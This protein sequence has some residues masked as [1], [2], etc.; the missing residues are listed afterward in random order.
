MR[1]EKETEKKMLKKTVLFV[2]ALLF[3]VNAAFAAVNINKADQAALEALP[4]IGA[5]K[6]T[7]II[8]YRTKHGNFKTKEELSEVK[9]IGPKIMEKLKK[10]I[11]I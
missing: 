11:E 6:A 7:A 5:K 4:G 3:F 9:G 1:K 2:F 8:D 10:D